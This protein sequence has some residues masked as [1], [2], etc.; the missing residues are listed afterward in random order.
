MYR[1]NFSD[2][3][4]SSFISVALWIVLIV[5]LGISSHTEM[6]ICR[7]LYDPDYRTMEA[8]LETQAFLGRT[9]TVPLKELF[10]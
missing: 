2:A 5:A 7:P 6:L 3:V 10:E 9:L 8:V 1:S 4:T